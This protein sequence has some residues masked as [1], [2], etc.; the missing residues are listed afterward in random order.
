M[1]NSL[2][3][4]YS[5][6]IHG[7]LTATDYPTDRPTAGG[8][9]RLSTY[10]SSLPG[11]V[12]YLDNGD[13][14]QGSPLLDYARNHPD[15]F[16]DPVS[17]AFNHLNL[18]YLTLGNHDFNY[19]MTHLSTTLSRMNATVLCCNILRADGS[20][21][22]NPHAVHVTRSGHRIGLIGAITN[23][24]PKWEKPEHIAGLTFADAYACLEQE[25]A[26]LRPQVDLVVVLYHG[27]FEADLTTGLPVGRQTDEN[28]GARIASIPGIDL[29]LTGHQHVPTVHDRPNIKI[30]QTSFSARDVGVATVRFDDE[31]PSIACSLHRLTETEDPVLVETLR[32]VETATRTWLDGYLGETDQDMTIAD[33]LSCRIRKHPLFQLIN[34]V[35][36]ANTGATISCASLPNHPP[37]FAKRITRRDVAA[38]FVYPNTIFV[39]SVTGKI[40][41]AAL[42]RS[43]E[44]FEHRDGRIVIA[45]AFVKPKLEHYNYD[46]YDGIEYD[47]DV[48]QPKGRRIVRLARLGKPVAD[49]EVFALALNNYRAAGGGDYAMFE[50]ASV[51]REF[52]QPLSDWIADRIAAKS[53]LHIDVIR[54]FNVY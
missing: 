17:A 43:A 1:S 22:F 51:I 54:N 38:N 33:A 42:E 44:Y 3:I 34:E 15:F 26:F 46:V 4:V 25:V 36:I 45:E 31:K 2:T 37:G 41:R 52:D 47:I 39:L 40:L 7:Q 35:Q 18:R 8:L 6:D 14:L 5:S 19:G 27:G 24:V 32:P 28:Q 29:L 48:S 20:R 50:D 10:L 49:D 53:P 12:L 9:T 11:E 16:F 23:Y 13:F 21:V 30:L